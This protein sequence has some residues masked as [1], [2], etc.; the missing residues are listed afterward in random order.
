MSWAASP[1]D[2]GEALG[3]ARMQQGHGVLDAQPGQR[4]LGRRLRRDRLDGHFLLLHRP[5]FG[6]LQQMGHGL[7]FVVLAVGQAEFQADLDPLAA[8]ADRGVADGLVQAVGKGAGI[9][10][11]DAGADHGELRRSG[12]GHRVLQPHPLGQ[13][14][15]ELL[16]QLFADGAAQLVDQI[17]EAVELH[18]DDADFAAMPLRQGQGLA[19]LLLEVFLG[20][21]AGLRIDH[22]LL[23]HR[24][25]VRCA[26]AP[27]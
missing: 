2:A 11:A 14:G 21:Q 7:P 8:V 5:P 13:H 27:A 20:R 23:G 3:I 24:L 9:L 25:A 22:D 4:R 16:D 17:V 1:P 10:Q 6:Q 12:L 26:S 15:A 18:Y 19:T